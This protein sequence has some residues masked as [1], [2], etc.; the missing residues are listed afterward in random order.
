MDQAPRVE[1]RDSAPS[2]SGRW[3]P[4]VGAGLMVSLPLVWLLSYAALL[5]FFLG[6]FF[7]ALF[8]LV[9]GAA[10]HRVASP[11]GPYSPV[12]V[13]AGTTLVVL[14][15]FGLSLLKESRD[16][17]S[18]LA[19]DAVG[20][21]ADLHGRTAAEY[22]AA[23]EAEVRAFLK[24]TYPPGRTLGY[25]RWMAASGEIK[26]GALPSVHR[27]LRRSPNGS[28]FIVRAALSV[29]LL[30]FGVGSQTLPLRNRRRAAAPVSGS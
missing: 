24:A 20:R 30:A 11:A 27:S 1:P 26:K 21:T 12:G 6:V 4:G 14:L 9:I 13:L 18:D 15:V 10:I 8:G 19:H 5:P 17:P 25:V 2:T 23:V 28:W 22:R 29:G 7:F 3:W 16:F